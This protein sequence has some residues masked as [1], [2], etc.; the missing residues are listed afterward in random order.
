M[1]AV[2]QSEL[3]AT[4][5]VLDRVFLIKNGDHAGSSFTVDVDGRQYLITAKHLVNGLKETDDIEIYHESQWKKLNVKRIELKNPKID[6]AVLAPSF[7]LS[8]SSELEPSV[9]GLA[10]SQRVLFL[11]FPFGMNIEAKSFLDTEI[12]FLTYTIRT[13]RRPLKQL[14][15]LEYS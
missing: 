10:L 3:M 14:Q 12:S 8:P 1:I 13:R 2:A 7:Q 5:N 11:G 15:T 9:D 6:I 4:S